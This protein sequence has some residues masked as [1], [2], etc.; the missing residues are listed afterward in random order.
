MGRILGCTRHKQE[1]ESS[2]GHAAQ[3]AT[4]Q[5]KALGDAKMTKPYTTRWIISLVA[6]AALTAV[7]VK[8]DELYLSRWNG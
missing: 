6:A 3:S 4:N 7:P 2:R 8:A 5:P 1:T